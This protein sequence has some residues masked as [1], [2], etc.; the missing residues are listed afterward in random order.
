MSA[1]LDAISQVAQ[2]TPTLE[3]MRGEDDVLRGEFSAAIE[4]L[5][6]S[7]QAPKIEDFRALIVS[8]V[9]ARIPQ[10][11][12]PKALCVED[13]RPM[14]DAA[15]AQAT[16][17]LER[18]GRAAIEREIDR[19]PKPVKGDPGADGSRFEGFHV[20]QSGRT[21]TMSMSFDGMVH[22]QSVHLDFPMELGVYQPGRCYQKSDIVTFAGS[23]FI[24]TRDTTEK[25]KPES[26]TAWRLIVKR[27]RDGK[28]FTP[29]G[30][31]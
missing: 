24:A 2:T 16:L 29:E 18:S 14:L 10:F 21:V 6:T 28:D 20:E 12:P 1:R 3:I 25:E 13:V 17:E 30:G 15:I 8:E 7:L 5:K 27:G 4:Q 26:S 23:Q 11:E 31:E 22:Q 19:M 9:E